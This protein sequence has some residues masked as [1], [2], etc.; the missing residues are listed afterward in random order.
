[1]RFQFW[2]QICR[3]TQFNVDVDTAAGGELGV[4]V[5]ATDHPPRNKQGH[6]G[7]PTLW[8][9]EPTDDALSLLEET[10]GDEPAL[11]DDEPSDDVHALLEENARLRGLL[12]QLSD[13][14]RRN[15]VHA[16]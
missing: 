16:R 5:M 12:V 14:I 1:M 10:A 4:L 6:L 2:S 15:L 13:L 7:E 11:W 9:D 8:A 3:P